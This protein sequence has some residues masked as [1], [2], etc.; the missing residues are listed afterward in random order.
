M[1]NKIVKNEQWSM[2]QLISKIDNK[3]ITKPKFQRKKKWSIFQEKPNIPNEKAYIQFLYDTGN[4][5]H[6]ITFGQESNSG[7]ITYSNI[8][9]NNRINTIKHFMDKPFEIF[10]EYLEDL[11]TYIDS[12][13]LN[14]DEK[15][16]LKKIFNELSYNEIMKFKY[17]K[18]FIHNG[19]KEF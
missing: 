11:K 10:I 9:G 17:N 7:R 14:P 12:V 1:T 19:H 13:Q 8:D 16:L 15:R 4:S 6:P 3:D 18:Y 5:V 2:K